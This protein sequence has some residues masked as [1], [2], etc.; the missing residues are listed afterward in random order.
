M[1]SY[2]TFIAVPPTFLE[3]QD[4]ICMALQYPILNIDATEAHPVATPDSTGPPALE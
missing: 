1:E 2:S 4:I 3:H